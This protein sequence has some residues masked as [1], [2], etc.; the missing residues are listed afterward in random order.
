MTRFT[1]TITH[2]SI[3]R[4]PTVDVGDTIAAAKINASRAFGDGLADH[5]ITI[6]DTLVSPSHKAQG[7]DIVAS[8]RVGDARWT[9]NT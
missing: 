6:T 2:H 1:A 7:Y 8:R 4:S 3:G 5:L 9:I